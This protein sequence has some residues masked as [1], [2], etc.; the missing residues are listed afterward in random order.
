MKGLTDAQVAA[1]IADPLF[2]NIPL[3]IAHMLVRKTEWDL[4]IGTDPCGFGR[5]GAKRLIEKE[6]AEVEKE[7]EFLEKRAE[8]VREMNQLQEHAIERTTSWPDD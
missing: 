1:I 6:D 7:A 3:D 2:A 8:F 4:G 5:H